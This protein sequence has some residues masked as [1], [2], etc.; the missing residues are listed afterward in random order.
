MLTKMCYLMLTNNPLLCQFIL[1]ST[2]GSFVK[3]ME[4]NWI[5]LSLE[6]DSYFWKYVHDYYLFPEVKHQNS[7]H[8]FTYLPE[9]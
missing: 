3:D 5:L 9:K 1:S 6:T 8:T 2:Y 4:K 7:T